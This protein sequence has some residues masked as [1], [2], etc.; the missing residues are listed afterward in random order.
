MILRKTCVIIE[1]CTVKIPSELYLRF[2][3]HVLTVQCI[4]PKLCLMFLKCD[5]ATYLG[6][7]CPLYLYFM[8]NTFYTCQITNVNVD[9][10]YGTCTKYT[11]KNKIHHTS[12]HLFAEVFRRMEQ[13]KT[14]FFREGKCSVAVF[15]IRYSII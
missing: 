12:L 11:L 3:Y 15:N 5:M 4:Q 14:N 2:E 10:G 6:R 7:L 1:K 13:E 9:Q 8:L